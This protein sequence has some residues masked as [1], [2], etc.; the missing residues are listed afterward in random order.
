VLHRA[1]FRFL[2][3]DKRLPGRPDI[4]FPKYKTV[5][6]VHGCFWHRHSGCRFTTHPATRQDFWAAKFKANIRR[7]SEVLRLLEESGWKVAVLWECETRDP[8]VL[9]A[10]LDRELPFWASGRSA[11]SA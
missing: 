4:V 7:D 9:V 3:H 1:G 6:F 8:S 10:A 11:L 5:L 2:L